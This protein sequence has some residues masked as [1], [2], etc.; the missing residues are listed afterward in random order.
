MFLFF[1]KIDKLMSEK[2]ELEF[3]NNIEKKPWQCPD[4]Y[5][6]DL[7]KTEGGAAITN[8]ED[9]TYHPDSQM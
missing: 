5:C 3:N 2:M 4:L 7:S 1:N 9:E 8:F 6:L